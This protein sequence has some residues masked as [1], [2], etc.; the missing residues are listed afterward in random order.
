VNEQTDAGAAADTTAAAAGDRIVLVPVKAFHR[1][2]VRLTPALDPERRR[3]L[4]RSM[5]SHVV[6]S[7]SPLPVAV[8]CDDPIVAEWVDE[9]GARL[10]WT[11]GTG[12]N[13]AVTEGVRVL[14]AA[15]Y[16]QVIIAHGDLPFSTGFDAFTTWPGVTIAPDR[17]RTGTNV[18][19]V[20]TGS[21]FQFS[22]GTGSFRRHVREAT[23]L[24]TGL[25]IV[26]SMRLG[27]DIDLPDDLDGLDPSYPIGPSTVT[28]PAIS[29]RTNPV[30]PTSER[31]PT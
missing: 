18:L 4:A 11:P 7:A 24:R 6:R 20:R 21:G 28:K 12:L 8:V 22:Y 17:H 9:V 26:L 10:I 31:M 30:R 1:A 16:E 27:W 25:R 3:E 15:G 29:S 5:A 19:A 2:K 23:R 13:G 14:G